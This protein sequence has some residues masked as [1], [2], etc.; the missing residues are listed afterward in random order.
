MADPSLGPD[1]GPKL[2]HGGGSDENHL[3]TELLMF[4]AYVLKC[5]VPR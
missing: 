5:I 1:L 4:Y 3:S 2:N